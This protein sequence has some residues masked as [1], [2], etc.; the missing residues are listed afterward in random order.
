MKYWAKVGQSQPGLVT[1]PLT[2]MA[3]RTSIAAATHRQ[4]WRDFTTVSCSGSMLLADS[5]SIEGD[6][7]CGRVTRAARVVV[8]T[9]VLA[10]GWGEVMVGRKTKLPMR[11]D[12]PRIRD[13][14]RS[15]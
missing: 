10:V 1:R 9:G 4:G 11:P 8:T 6:R 2:N 15:A 12:V 7:C 14:P 5:R 3:T 13:C